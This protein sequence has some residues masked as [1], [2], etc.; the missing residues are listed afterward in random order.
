MR[1]L[2]AS[3]LLLVGCGAHFNTTVARS[4]PFH[5][6]G[7]DIAD[8]PQVDSAVAPTPSQSLSA[9]IAPFIPYYPRPAVVRYHA[10]GEDGTSWFL[11]GGEIRPEE[12]IPKLLGA[13]SVAAPEGARTLYGVV[14]DF[15]WYQVGRQELAGGRIATQLTLVAADGTILFEGEH[16]TEGRARSV[17]SLYRAHVQ[18]W[19][20][21]RQFLAAVAPARGAQ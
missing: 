21:D 2:L 8:Y 6:H 12:E 19:L 14:T 11:G 20:R 1:A 4:L 16:S 9:K 3:S 17:D 5:A 15:Q 10:G 7:D 13:S 18:D